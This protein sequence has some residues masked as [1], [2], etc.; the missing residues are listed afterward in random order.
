LNDIFF[1]WQKNQLNQCVLIV[2]TSGNHKAFDIVS[3]FKV[4][5][6]TFFCRQR[7]KVFT[8]FLIS[9]NLKISPFVYVNRR[10]SS[11]SICE[12]LYFLLPTI[13]ETAGIAHTCVCHGLIKYGDFFALNNRSFKMYKT[14]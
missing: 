13:C 4:L 9:K 10:V 5:L 14:F 7:V 11:V 12:L 8:H 1:W 2:L 6:N 3:D